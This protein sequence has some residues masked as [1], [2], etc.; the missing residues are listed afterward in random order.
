MATIRTLSC[1]PCPQGAEGIGNDL[2]FTL[3]SP[4]VSS[5][6]REEHEALFQIL[7][8]SG[9][10]HSNLACRN[11]SQPGVLRKLSIFHF[12]TSW[13][14]SGFF[15]PL[16]GSWSQQFLALVP[17]SS[18]QGLFSTG[19]LLAPPGSHSPFPSCSWCSSFSSHSTGISYTWLCHCPLPPSSPFCLDGR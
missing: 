13:L 4:L 12:Y 18:P 9:A 14:H 8:A 17:C 15:P 7:K 1:S 10:S 2:P 19:D 3:S 16:A 5:F 11:I 6:L